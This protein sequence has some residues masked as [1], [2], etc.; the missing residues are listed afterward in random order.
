MYLRIILLIYDQGI[1]C[2]TNEAYTFYNWVAQFCSLPCPDISFSYS[3]KINNIRGF[4]DLIRILLVQLYIQEHQMKRSTLRLFTH[5]LY[6]FASDYT[7]YILC[8]FMWL[9][10]AY[11][12]SPDRRLAFVQRWIIVTIAH[13]APLEN[14]YLIS[15]QFPDHWIISEHDLSGRSRY[16]V[17]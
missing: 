11:L 7:P 1:S 5:V 9:S 13:V 8:Y 10:C 2:T 17:Y 15:R 4:M 12:S 14:T 16:C 3:F 6:S